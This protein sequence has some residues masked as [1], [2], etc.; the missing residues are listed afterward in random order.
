MMTMISLPLTLCS[1]SR[2]MTFRESAE[3][4]PE[5]GSSTKSTLGSRISSKAMFSR[6][7]CPR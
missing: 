7:R 1:L 3:D 2:L 4:R 5:V 6:L